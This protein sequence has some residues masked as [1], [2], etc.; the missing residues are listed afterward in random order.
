M[1]NLS[2][3]LRILS[4][5]IP[6]SAMV[7]VQNAIIQRQM[8]FRQSF[9]ASIIGTVCG[10]VTG[11]SL[12]YLGYGVWSLVTQQLLTRFINMII[13][14][15]SV[16]WRPVLKF[17]ALRIGIMHR[18]SWKI[19][20]GGLIDSV[21]NE[22][23]SLFIGKIYTASD[24]AFYSKGMSFPRLI[25]SNIDATISSVLFPALSA[26]QDDVDIVKALTRRAVKTSS[27]IIWPLMMGLAVISDK[28]IPL[29]LTEKWIRSIPYLKVACVYYA[30]FPIC[31]SNMQAIKAMGHS[32]IYLKLEIVK[33]V[34]GIV[35][36]L[37]AVRI[38]VMA[39]VLS[40]LVTTIIAMFLN[41]IPSSKLI[42]YGIKE[43]L[44]DL[45]PS[46]L[47]T[48]A[49]VIVVLAVSY[50]PLSDFFV[51]ILQLFFGVVSYLLM[52]RVF[53]IEAFEYVIALLQQIK[54][55]DSAPS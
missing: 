35:L 26:S 53:H 11:I 49:M 16:K 43:Q 5:S 25:I 42:A 37:L 1:D 27:Y 39:V 3:I 18:Y 17:S 19:L 15:T 55:R 2:P 40:T 24:L 30:L 45:L 28:L 23:R 51:L 50:L 9:N 46:A 31:T 20:V 54:R 48:L 47:V 32:D 4:L 36:M 12:A 13:L 44:L 14:W 52:S 10:A 6:V 41:A 8:T 7:T 33:K 29:L 22:S 34:I 38:S 21:Y